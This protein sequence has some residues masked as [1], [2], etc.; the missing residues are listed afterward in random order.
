MPTEV[1]PAIAPAVSR[2]IVPI[3]LDSSAK[4]WKIWLTKASAA[5]GQTP[6]LLV[7]S[8]ARK[9]Y[10]RVWNDTNAVCAITPKQCKAISPRW[11]K[12]HRSLPPSPKS[13]VYGYAYWGKK[14]RLGTKT[15]LEGAPHQ[16]PPSLLLPHLYQCRSN[17]LVGG[18]S[19]ALNLE[20]DL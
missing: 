8:V 2:R 3:S 18:I 9:L 11:S 12:Q 4:S 19:G 1:T 16:S 15:K 20:K 6:N 17:A 7:D 14:H 13:V 10:R 5:Q